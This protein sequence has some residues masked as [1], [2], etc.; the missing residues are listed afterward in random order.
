MA[1]TADSADIVAQPAIPAISPRMIDE[2]RAI[3]GNDGVI[4]EEAQRRTYESDGLASYRALPGVVVLAHQH[5]TGA[6]CR[7]AVRTRG[8]P[9]RAARLGHRAFRRRAA[10]AGLCADRALAHAPDSRG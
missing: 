3:L 2:L 9:I 8:H 6:R 4:I 1:D 5:R 7:A 10:H